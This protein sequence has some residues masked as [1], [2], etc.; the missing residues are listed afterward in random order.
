[1][2]GSQLHEG[3]DL[4]DDRVVDR[5][6]PSPKADDGDNTSSVAFH[7]ALIVFR[8]SEEVVQYNLVLVTLNM[9]VVSDLLDSNS[10]VGQFTMDAKTITVSHRHQACLIETKLAEDYHPWPGRESRRS[11]IQE[12]GGRPRVVQP[13]CR[14]A[15]DPEGNHGR[16]VLLC[17]LL[18]I[19]P[20]FD[21]RKG[22]SVPNDG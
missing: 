1:M 5:W 8:V 18:E 11:L 17:K 7:V 12:L 10:H 4:G 13:D 15:T 20:W 6:N 14:I 21:V 16:I 2:L 3:N 9:C 19:D 22:E